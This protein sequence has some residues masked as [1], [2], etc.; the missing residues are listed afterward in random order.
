MK[1]RTLEENEELKSNWKGKIIIVSKEQLT[2]VFDKRADREIIESFQFINSSKIDTYG[3]NYLATFNF[4]FSEQSGSASKVE[5]IGLYSDFKTFSIYVTNKKSQVLSV[6]ENVLPKSTSHAGV[7]M[8]LI[9]ELTEND[10]IKL[11]GIENEIGSLDDKIAIERN[12]EGYLKKIN[13]YKK[14][15]VRYK[16]HYEQ[17]N[18]I[19]DFFASHTEFFSTKEEKE[20]YLV[21]SK[22]IPRLYKEIVYLR[23]AV[24]QTRENY[25]SQIESRQNSLMKTFTVITA[26]FMPLQLI[27]GWYGMNLMMPEF[28]WK[29]AYLTIII[30]SIV[31]VA[32]MLIIFKKKK[33][34]K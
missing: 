34:F 22:R 17:L 6:I 8:N 16:H 21:V 11:E 9:S 5:K 3:E 19:I 13:T 24:A 12:I 4:I 30:V 15:T 10:Y 29:Y 14:I 20:A 27:V 28:H 31:L 18:Y 23:D 33:W 1:V 7:L 25:Q 2:N 26:I 32:C